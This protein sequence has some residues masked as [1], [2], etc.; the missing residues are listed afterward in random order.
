M[1]EAPISEFLRQYLTSPPSTYME[2]LKSQ[3]LRKLFLA[4]DPVRSK[5]AADLK[6]GTRA[7]G[8]RA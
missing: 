1:A 7:E 6:R 2:A 5:T 3:N 8:L 4:P